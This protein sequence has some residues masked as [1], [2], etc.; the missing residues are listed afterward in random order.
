[1]D[2]WGTPTAP[3]YVLAGRGVR[4]VAFLLN[5]VLCVM[6]LALAYVV[7]PAAWDDPQRVPDPATG[8]MVAAHGR[9]TLV[10]GAVM[11]GGWALVAVANMVLV[12]L[13]SQ[14]LGKLLVGIEIRRQDGTR[15]G[16]WR[17]VGLRF[18][19]SGLIGNSVPFYSIV[20]PLFIFRQD[21]RCV[22]DLIAGTIV[23]V[24][25]PGIDDT[26]PPVLPPLT[27]T[28]R[29]QPCPTCGTGARADAVYCSSCG[30]RLDAVPVAPGAGPPAL[31]DE[32]TFQW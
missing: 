12:A 13:R 28:A 19:V 30:N 27:T 16:F 17:I 18:M 22:H 24:R 1:V 2:D 32:E 31:P 23:V 4:F 7:A 5:V 21:R 14:S 9:A 20:D 11:L 3:T 10:F 25:D 15:A 6:P 29:Q 8:E 26:G